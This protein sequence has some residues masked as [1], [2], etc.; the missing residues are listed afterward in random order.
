MCSLDSV[1]IAEA[2][3][4]SGGMLFLY[5][6]FNVLR[7]LARI[8]IMTD[9]FKMTML[10]FKIFICQITGLFLTLLRHSEYSAVFVCG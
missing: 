10:N 3:K 8:Y 2:A 4:S 7:F 5:F 1:G 6:I 9:F